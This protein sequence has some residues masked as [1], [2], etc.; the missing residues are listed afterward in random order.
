MNKILLYGS[1]LLLLGL[2][3]PAWLTPQ[4]NSPSLDWKSLRKS[5][6]DIHDSKARLES[7]KKLETI[8]YELSN[9]LVD[10]GSLA[11]GDSDARV[12]RQAAITLQTI[13]LSAHIVVPNLIQGLSREKDD[14][15]RA[16]VISVFY[17]TAPLSKDAIPLLLKAAQDRNVEIRCRAIAALGAFGPQVKEAVPLLIQALRDPDKKVPNRTWSGVSSY[18]YRSL[19]D[20]DADAKIAFK[21]VI[22]MRREE[23]A[24]LRKRSADQLEK[25]IPRNKRLVPFIA[26]WLSEPSDPERRIYSAYALGIIGP[27]ARDAVPDLL[28]VLEAKDVEDEGTAR[29]IRIGAVWALGRIGPPAKAALPKLQEMRD[30]ASEPLRSVLDTALGEIQKKD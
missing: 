10:L 9:T 16:E 24:E 26:A 21:A 23:P 18:A 25:F 30:Q 3:L 11:A 14:E 8:A 15:V 5:L 29:A 17:N 28:K 7:A 6:R 27:D 4:D 22:G 12:R 20:I 1:S 19:M 13:G 2:V